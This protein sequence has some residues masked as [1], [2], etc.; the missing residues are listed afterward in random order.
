MKYLK[1]FESLFQEITY[2]IGLKFF[3]NKKTENFNKREAN[4]I[5]KFIQTIKDR[6]RDCKISFRGN[7]NG[8]VVMLDI[9]GEKGSI[10]NRIYID[11]FEDEYFMCT[12]YDLYFD[13]KEWSHANN[14]NYEPI[15]Y[16]CDSIDGLSDF[17]GDEIFE[18]LWKKGGR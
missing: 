15:T 17:L 11:K 1:T 18:I 16:K 13:G 8:S 3:S 10:S 14:I 6:Y 9:I 2:D 12:I 4:I 5:N 7:I